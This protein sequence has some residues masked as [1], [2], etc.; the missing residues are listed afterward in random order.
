MGGLFGFLVIAKLDCRIGD[1]SVN[2]YIVRN[3]VIEHARF[4]SR[5]FE[6]L[7]PEE[8][9]N[10]KLPAVEIIGIDSKRV[11]KSFL[12]LI[13]ESRISRLPCSLHERHGQIVVR[14][15]FTGILLDRAARCC[16]LLLRRR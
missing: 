3:L 2:H 9:G 13:A 8:D 14:K 10:L 16:D 7:L 5:L 6:F 4:V 12:R 11:V 1:V 15:I